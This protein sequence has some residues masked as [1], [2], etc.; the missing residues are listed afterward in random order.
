VAKFFT[1]K[2]FASGMRAIQ[3]KR[4]RV[5]RKPNPPVKPLTLAEMLTGY[6]RVASQETTQRG[7]GNEY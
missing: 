2:T 1:Q 7:R 5:Y 3:H 4:A 6:Q